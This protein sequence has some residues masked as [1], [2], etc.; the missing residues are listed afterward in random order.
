MSNL[1]ISLLLGLAVL[2]TTNPDTQNIHVFEF[3]L[4]FISISLLLIVFLLAAWTADLLEK[5]FK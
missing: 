1:K 3:P 5:L 4:D 2:I